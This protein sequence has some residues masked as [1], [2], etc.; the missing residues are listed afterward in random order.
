MQSLVIVASGFIVEEAVTGMLPACSITSK[1]GAG[2][3]VG[4]AASFIRPRGERPLK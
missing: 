2:V 1:P 4:P 3:P